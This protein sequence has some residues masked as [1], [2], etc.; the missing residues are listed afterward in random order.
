[1]A[2]TGTEEEGQETG[3]CCGRVRTTPRLGGG[4]KAVLLDML[5]FILC[6][7]IC[8]EYTSS[9]KMVLFWFGLVFRDPDLPPRP[10][11]ST[12]LSLLSLGFKG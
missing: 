4:D 6:T 7:S 3:C 1:M 10:L 8:Q 11:R 5:P 2:S 12:G 9:G